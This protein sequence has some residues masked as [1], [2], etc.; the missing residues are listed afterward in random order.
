MFDYRT[1]SAGMVGGMNTK[2][3]PGPYWAYENTNGDW[4]VATRRDHDPVDIDPYDSA[5]S[6]CWVG[7]NS[8]HT[9]SRTRGNGKAVAYLLAAAPDLYDALQAIVIDDHPE[10]RLRPDQIYGARM[11]LKKARGEQ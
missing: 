7:D 3:T 9:E 6:I 2:W 4:C 8:D 5:A 11:A 1:F 10:T